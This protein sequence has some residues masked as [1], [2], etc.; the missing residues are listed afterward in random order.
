[1]Q[2]ERVCQALDLPSL[3]PTIFNPA[4][5][6]DIV[7][8]HC[9][10][11]AIQYSCAKSWLDSGLQVDRIIGH[12]FGQLTGLCV[13]GGLE[14]SDALY[15]VSERARLIRDDWGS[16]RGVMLSVEASSAEVQH[17]LSQSPDLLLDVACVNGTRNIILAGDEISV[18][19]FEKISAE[20][21]SPMRTRRLKNTHAFHSRLVDR[22][23]P[24]F[25]KIAKGLQYLPL[26]I[27]LEACS[28]D[29][30]WSIVTPADIVNHSRHQVHFQKAVERAASKAQGPAVWL[31]AG[32]ASPIIPMIRRVVEATASPPIKHV[33]QA[34]DLEGPL[35]QKKLSEA[36]SNLWGNGVAVQFWPFH[37][38]QA[39]M[40][41]WINL[42]PYQFT[43]NRHWVD[44]NPFAFTP[45][46]SSPAVILADHP[47]VFMRILRK[48][49]TECLCAINTEDH[50]Y[51]MCTSGHAV[52]DQ[53]LCPASLY[54]EMVVRAADLAQSDR[55]SSSVMPH[56]QNMEISAPLVLNP[57]GDVLLKLS[58]ARPEQTAWS[59]SLYTTDANQAV[60]VHA[61]GEISLHPLNRPIP[62][63]ARLNSMERLIDVSRVQAIQNSPASSGLKGIAVYQA[64]RRVVNYAESYRG[65]DCVYATE[66]ESAGVV[67]LPSSPTHDSACDPILMDNFIQ[68]AGIHVNCLSEI[69]SQE[70]YVCTEIG[71]FLIGE[72]FLSRA[73]TSSE[74]WDIYSN[75]DRSVKGRIAC[76]IF[77]LSR[78]SGKLAVA[79]LAVTFKS[80]PINSLTRALKGLNNQ[81]D[82]PEVTGK[83]MC[84]E[85]PHKETVHV[86]AQSSPASHPMVPG[87]DHFAEVQAM[88][89]DMLGMPADELLPSSNL[90]DI[91][92]DS[93]MRTEVLAE[94]KKRFN[95]SIATSSM[96]DIPDVQ[97]LV[98][99]ISPEGSA[100]PLTN[101]CY[102]TLPTKTAY[103]DPSDIDTPVIATST[104]VEASP[105]M[106]EIAPYI[107]S[108][109]QKTTVH[110][111]AT[112]WD[113]FYDSVYRKQ[114]ELVTAYVVEAF[115]SLGVA[116]ENLQPE[117][118]LPHVA[119][120]PQHDQ[121]MGQLYAILESSELIKPANGGFRRTHTPVSMVSSSELHEEILR[122]YPQHASE[123]K[124]LKTTGSRL[125]DCLNGTADPLGLLFR[126]AEA[127]DLMADVYTNAPMFNAAT[128]H[129]SEYLV[130]V[131]GR[132]DT[133][134][135]IR[136]L[137]IGAGT[138][139]TTKA[140]LNQLTDVPGLR[141]EYTFT[142]LSSGL[143]TLARK[144]FKQYNFMK[145]QVL[146]IEQDPTPEML[147]QYDIIISSN[148]I[149]ATRNLVTS[150]INIRKLLRPD[151]ILCLIELTRNLFWF[152]LVFGLLEGWW[153]FD[154][155]R[156]HA[157]AT[158]HVWKDN[159]SRSGFEWVSWSLN[160]S[161]ESNTLRLIT[162]SPTPA[163]SLINGV[164][165]NTSLPKLE[166]VVYGEKN[167]VKLCA[168][169]YYPES[170]Q[171]SGRRRP[172]GM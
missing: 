78:A 156:K 42:P 130:G 153:L 124:L 59:F 142:D 4:P 8:L 129:L 92:V 134:R 94:I 88:L 26:S 64:F 77:V 147:G 45:S 50:L 168:D 166:T 61:T 113:G 169:I 152:D 105:G 44:Y 34:I 82:E 53:N 73:S 118:F 33:Y 3:F 137:E 5:I 79:I 119:V 55:S 112:E 41:N 25:T 97:A 14:L 171:P 1:M 54:I 48:N 96:I 66:Y 125:A 158:E 35:A 136:I 161:E 17:L 164:D 52:V 95:V 84:R 13:S 139:G 62:I 104:S 93:L 160:D 11:F 89:C 165:A 47:S 120:L 148:C 122:L 154:D 100:A 157:L 32:S 51:Q 12:S 144:K 36:T 98:R 27:P 68:V 31:E 15:L 90:E 9:I 23:V 170:L 116:M 106:M 86:F 43:Q 151:G 10:L 140:L 57:R 80:I 72:A 69:R 114:M 123:H 75:V 87:P 115:R 60:I 126:D 141:L 167:G 109:I 38:F 83:T 108:E 18:Q 143:L 67:T 101:G 65:V 133:S 7:S 24:A 76:D 71:E 138:G 107:F 155:G 102:V 74:S 99:T 63:F 39:K 132:L 58:R 70:V 19:S 162:A 111:E 103:L 22:I 159:L 56:V 135:Q 20:S 28:D 30:D 110:A 46:H 145:Y 150:S 172:I 81:H 21:P 127:R 16:E 146:N 131:L 37:R 163:A 121:V 2:C 29:G 128:R 117:Q 149:H 40:Y 85:V 91:G 6:D 49:S